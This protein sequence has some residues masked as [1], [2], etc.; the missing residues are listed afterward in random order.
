MSNRTLL[1]LFLRLRLQSFWRRYVRSLCICTNQR[2]FGKQESTRFSE[3]ERRAFAATRGSSQ[4]GRHARVVA[5][6]VDRDGVIYQGT[7]G[8]ADVRNNVAMPANAIFNIA[9]MTKPVTSVA[10]MML[11]EQ[12][13]L[14]LDDPVSKYLTGFDNLQVITKFN[15]KDALTKRVQPAIR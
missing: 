11:L 3:A 10:I 5:L 2:A 4:P 12:G 13:K 6:V 15:E 14:K 9:S 1:A 8:K 7:A